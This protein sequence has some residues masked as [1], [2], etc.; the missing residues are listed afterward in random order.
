M[1]R[2]VDIATRSACARPICFG[3]SSPNTIVKRVNRIVTMMSA[4]ALAALRAGRMSASQ[5]ATPS[6]RLTAAKAEARKP[7]KLMPIWMTA[8]KRPGFALRRWTRDAR[9]VAL[10]DELL[11]PAAAERDERDL[12]RREDAVEQDQDGDESELEDGATHD[13]VAD[14]PRRS[15]RCGVSSRDARARGCAP[16][17]PTA[18]L[19]AARPW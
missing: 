17:T 14:R 6:T 12:G 8:R 2:A 4:M 11:D 15:R 3:T 5:S 9:P 18:S 13:R 10:V 19:P 7:R 16:G 1:S